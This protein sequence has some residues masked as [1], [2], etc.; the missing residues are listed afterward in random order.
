MK[1][2]DEMTKSLLERRDSYAA[3]RKAR[4]KKITAAATVAACVCL[5][6]L[7]GIGVLIHG[8]P[9][10]Q[11]N[12]P[13]TGEENIIKINKVAFTP[14]Y[15]AKPNAEGNEK[16]NEKADLDKVDRLL[17]E[18][19]NLLKKNPP[20]LPSDLIFDSY[21]G[22]VNTNGS[23]SG[24][25]FSSEDKSRTVFLEIQN[26]KTSNET[27]IL[28]KYCLNGNWIGDEDWNNKSLDKSTIGGKDVSIALSDGGN[29]FAYFT[30]N[31][32]AFRIITTGIT[33]EEVIS[34]IESFVK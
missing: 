24:F 10:K 11:E 2:Y 32:D 23:L 17:R 14:Q 31:G 25:S 1:S 6:V 12:R 33:Q 8:G 19:E 15:A 34:F 16:S 29:Y 18:N 28:G 26:G 7:L 20:K 9:A 27:N 4:N 30:H 3:A 21:L 22:E 13:E 5:S